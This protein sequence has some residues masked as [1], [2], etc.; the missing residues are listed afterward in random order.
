MNEQDK[1]MRNN[2]RDKWV[3]W[4]YDYPSNNLS[5]VKQFVTGAILNLMQIFEK[6]I[7]K[8][9]YKQ[10]NERNL[11]KKWKVMVDKERS[12]KERE[13]RFLKII[14]QLMKYFICFS[15]KSLVLCWLRLS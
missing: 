4:E 11:R 7:K 13:N 6:N 5:A 10:K 8:R 1:N 15:I 2:W 12:K 9:W 3:I 14:F